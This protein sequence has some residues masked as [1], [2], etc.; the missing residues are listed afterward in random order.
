MVV[1]NR[2]SVRF[3]N[4]AEKMKTYDRYSFISKSNKPYGLWAQTQYLQIYTTDQTYTWI[5]VGEG[6]LYI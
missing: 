5:W 3:Q 2:W 4:M 6:I 1:A